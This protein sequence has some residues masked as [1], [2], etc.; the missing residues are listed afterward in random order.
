MDLQTNR[1]INTLIN[2][3]Y[4][5]S[6]S[7]WAGGNYISWKD[8]QEHGMHLAQLEKESNVN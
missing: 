1:I 3:L 8:S 4:T 5:G 6:A 7:H 2:L